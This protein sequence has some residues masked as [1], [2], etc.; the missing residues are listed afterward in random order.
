MI[1]GKF[2]CDYEPVQRETIDLK[3]Q[4]IYNPQDNSNAAAKS[5][6]NNIAAV[7][8]FL[9]NQLRSNSILLF[10][11]ISCALFQ[12]FLKVKVEHCKEALFFTLLYLLGSNWIQ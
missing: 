3:G 4:A 2:Q 6:A 11:F 1:Y 9:Y 7:T 8:R 12:Y 5:G 10:D